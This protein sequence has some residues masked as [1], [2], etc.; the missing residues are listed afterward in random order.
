MV[1]TDFNENRIS[2][3]AA[4]I[5]YLGKFISSA[6]IGIGFLMVIFTDKKQALHNIVTKTVVINR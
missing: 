2:F 3:G 1:V 5:R 6:I 4:T